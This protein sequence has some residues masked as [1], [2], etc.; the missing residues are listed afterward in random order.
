MF[1]NGGAGG[2]SVTESCDLE[3]LGWRSSLAWNFWRAGTPLI[4]QP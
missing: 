1:A 4:L 2:E 3:I